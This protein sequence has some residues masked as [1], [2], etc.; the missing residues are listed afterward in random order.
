MTTI[1]RTI[2]D[3]CKA[4][5]EASAQLA[6]I[7]T[8]TKNKALTAMANAILEAI[9]FI[10]SENNKDIQQ[11]RDSGISNALI[12][13]LT[14]TDSRLVGISESIREIVA[15]KDPIGELLEGWVQPNGLKISKVRVP[16]GTIGIIYEARPNVTADAISLA[17]KTGNSVVLRGSSSAYYSNRAIAS[18][19]RDAAK[20]SGIPED[21]I[22]LLDDVSR[23]GVTTFIQLREYLSVIIPRGG[24]E[25]IR[26][27]TQNS[28]VPTIETGVGNCHVFVDSSADL[29]KANDI[30]FNSK[31]HRPAVCNACETLLV[32]RDVADAFMPVALTRLSD[33]GVEIRGCKET[34]RLFSKA[35]PA[36]DDDWDTEFADLI[37]A[38]K[39][40]DSSD[41]AMSHIRKHGSRHTESIVSND[42]ATI[43]RFLNNV[44]AAAVMVNASTRFT[45]GGQFGFGAEMG[46]STQKLHARGPM[47]LRELTTYKYIVQGDGHIRS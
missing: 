47:G 46:I 30:I 22:Q 4:A 20:D 17:L 15:L 11:G 23:E 7:T 18:V 9:P 26:S 27:V 35:T 1:Q 21:C 34:I 29:K 39:V 40:V 6:T 28:K 37:L 2:Q 36:T 19:L 5:F 45:D 25:L 16:L 12:D 38:V 33:A 24:A 44:D 8:E 13:R 10:L 31:T 43:E 32:H 14:L 3:Q 42:Y 41:S